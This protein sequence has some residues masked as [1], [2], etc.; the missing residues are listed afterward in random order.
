MQFVSF[1]NILILNVKVI[2]SGNKKFQFHKFYFYIY[3]CV[4]WNILES[5]QY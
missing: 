4:C 2:I 3:V 1:L 5:H